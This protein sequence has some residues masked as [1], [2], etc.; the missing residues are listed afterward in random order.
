MKQSMKKGKD[1]LESNKS[2]KVSTLAHSLRKLL[3]TL[4][5]GNHYENYKEYQMDL[6]L[7][8]THL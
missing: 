7:K 8:T 1:S 3:S 5:L 4:T 2:N 6:I